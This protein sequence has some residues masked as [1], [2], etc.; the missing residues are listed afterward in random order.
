MIRARSG[1][2][3]TCGRCVR[4]ESPATAARSPPPLDRA[5]QFGR[6]PLGLAP[7]DDVDPGEA[8]QQLLFDRLRAHAAQDQLPVGVARADRPH[9]QNREGQQVRHA[10]Q[11]DD[12]GRVA[13]EVEKD[14]HVERLVGIDALV[15]AEID[16]EAGVL[17]GAGQVQRPQR[18]VQLALHLLAVAHEEHVQVDQGDVG[19]GWTP[20]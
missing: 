15:V 3:V 20:S 5:E 1:V 12:R 11:A 17:Q 10:R 13:E 19:H 2:C 4:K 6:G 7:A 8:G 9:G 14:L 16:R 18:D